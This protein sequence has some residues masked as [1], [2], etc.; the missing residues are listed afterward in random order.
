MR[1]ARPTEFS[2][3]ESAAITKRSDKVSDKKEKKLEKILF[4]TN[5]QVVQPNT[6][7]N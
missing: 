4:G 5:E 7:K 1:K 3:Q 6:P 2:I